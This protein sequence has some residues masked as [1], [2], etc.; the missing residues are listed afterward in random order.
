M[1]GLQ[2]RFAWVEPMRGSAARGRPPFVP[3]WRALVVIGGPGELGS[4][5]APFGQ[6]GERGADELHH[7]CGTHVGWDREVP[8]RP[9]CLGLAKTKGAERAKRL[10]AD[11]VQ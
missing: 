3:G 2:L 6:R 9:T 7:A 4:V 11:V 10:R 8:Q 1:R 5:A